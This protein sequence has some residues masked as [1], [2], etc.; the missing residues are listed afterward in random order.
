[1]NNIY[2]LSEQELIELEGDRVIAKLGLVSIV[3]GSTLLALT[4]LV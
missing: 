4:S 1:M 3:I 2:N